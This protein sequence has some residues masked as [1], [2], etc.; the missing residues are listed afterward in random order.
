MMS[1]TPIPPSE[2]ATTTPSEGTTVLGEKGEAVYAKEE[3]EFFS[4][5]T[6]N[7]LAKAIFKGIPVEGLPVAGKQQPPVQVTKEKKE[8]HFRSAVYQVISIFK[9]YGLEA[10]DPLTTGWFATNITPEGKAA[11]RV[12]QG[13]AA[14]KQTLKFCCNR[15][16]SIGLYSVLGLGKTVKTNGIEGISMEKVF[17]HD[18]D[19]C[20]NGREMG[21][22]LPSYQYEV[23]DFDYAEV[24]GTTYEPVVERFKE[25]NFHDKEEDMLP[26]HSINFGKPDY[27]F[28]DRSYEYLP[29]ERYQEVL[30][31]DHRMAMARFNYLLAS[32]L[33]MADQMA[34]QVLD[35]EGVI[36]HHQTATL[37]SY[38]KEE[39]HSKKV[40][41]HPE[42][43]NPDFHLT[44]NEISLLFGGHSMMKV[45][46]EVP[47]KK[48][49]GKKKKKDD[50]SNPEVISPSYMVHQICHKDGE[51][52]E[53]EIQS[54]EKLRGKHKPGSFII[55][56]QDSRSIYILT[57]GLVI[58]ALKGQFIWFHGALPH[59]GLTYMASKEGNDWKPAI[60]GHLD[61]VHHARKRGDFTFEESDNVYF[62]LE[63]TKFMK[64]LFPILYKGVD[65]TWNATIEVNKRLTDPV[66]GKDY[67]GKMDPNTV[68][69]YNGVLC[70]NNDADGGVLINQNMDVLQLLEQMEI[71]SSRLKELVDLAAS[72]DL[73]GTKSNKT[74]LQT[75]TDQILQ[76]KLKSG[77]EKKRKQPCN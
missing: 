62:P 39:R 34:V 63:H 31:E 28:D 73:V 38:H 64:D 12:A 46:K 52:H 25:C 70:G 48:G 9:V 60:H 37:D 56:I 4:S 19:C 67:L 42:K 59:G 14:V 5:V 8:K 57:P 21:Y 3:A 69:K 44:F 2:V 6:P 33:N 27:K 1:S 74:K 23:F 20:A 51:T 75:L 72:G 68:K 30:E 50:K 76:G 16:K 40:S 29:S 43:T 15:C 58:T 53:G 26:G 49:K 41:K 77:V 17:Y 65:I 61:S 7:I 47:K 54:N 66:K 36:T 13:K 45:E 24:I 18:S 11:V 32:K 22:K 55:P 71:T 10:A 35:M